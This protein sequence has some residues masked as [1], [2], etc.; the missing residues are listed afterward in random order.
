MSG[1]MN[2]NKEPANKEITSKEVRPTST[3]VA[4]RGRPKGR[5]SDKR[6]FG[7]LGD[8]IRSHRIAKN[9][10][11]LDVAKACK[12]SVQFISNIEHGRAPLPWDKTE[13]LARFLGIAVEELQAANLAVRSD[14]RSFVKSS[15]A[16]KKTKAGQGGIP[17][18][19]AASLLALTAQ[20]P[21]LRELL[22]RYQSAPVSAR[23]KFYTQAK[24]ALGA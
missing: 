11:L 4:R 10:G 1:I 12:C 24:A 3:D 5:S 6:S 20:D 15:T 19:D 8:L 9:L 22:E 13:Q 17:F 21:L 16:G 2:L 18:K 23:K 7:P 14:F